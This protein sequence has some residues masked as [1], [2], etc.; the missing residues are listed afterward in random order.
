MSTTT[1][2]VS[3][4]S[5]SSSSSMT[6]QLATFLTNDPMCKQFGTLFLVR[7]ARRVIYACPL[8]MVQRSGMMRAIEWVGEVT[9]RSSEPVRHVTMK[10]ETKEM[11]TVTVTERSVNETS[12]KEDVI[13]LLADDE[14][15]LSDAAFQVTWN[16]INAMTDHP[17]PELTNLTLDV[18][19]QLWRHIDRFDMDLDSSF[20]KQFFACLN[21]QFDAK[22]EVA[23][24]ASKRAALVAFLGSTKRTPS[25]WHTCLDISTSFRRPGSRSESICPFCVRTCAPCLCP[26]F[27]S[28]CR[29]SRVSL[30]TPS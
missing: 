2:C 15:D 30:Q 9:R 11:S 8:V 20:V 4:S 7:K 13:C 3:T 29:L 10:E 1:K 12:E 16:W 5:D 27:R 21:D 18:L 19:Y 24:K 28:Q 22:E 25:K 26:R 6:N 14:I 17:Y 23:S